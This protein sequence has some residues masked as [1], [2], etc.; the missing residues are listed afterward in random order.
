MDGHICYI[1]SIGKVHHLLRNPADLIMR[2][3]LGLWENGWI[4]FLIINQKAPVN[5]FL[6][7]IQ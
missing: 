2:A 5:M 3:L 7:I 1:L 4:L 6:Q